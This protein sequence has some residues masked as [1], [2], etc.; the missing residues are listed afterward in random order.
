MEEQKS[1]CSTRIRAQVDVRPGEDI[2]IALRRFKKQVDKADIME[3]IYEKSFKLKPC[4]AKRE[5][6]KKKKYE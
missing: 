1:F 6:R 5:K 4:L 3:K 2:D